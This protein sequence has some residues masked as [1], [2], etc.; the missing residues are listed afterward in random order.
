MECTHCGSLK[1]VKNGSYK[2]VQ[3]YRSKTYFLYFN[4]TIRASNLVNVTIC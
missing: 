1:Y 2:G 3:G 4:L